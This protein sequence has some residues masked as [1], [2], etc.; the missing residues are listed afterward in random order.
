MEYKQKEYQ[1]SEVKDLMLYFVNRY[2]RY[3]KK[4][5]IRITMEVFLISY[6]FLANLDI[7]KR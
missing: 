6:N 4:K 5:C 3:L 1:Y 7:L 2:L